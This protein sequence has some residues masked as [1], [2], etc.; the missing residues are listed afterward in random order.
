MNLFNN[1]VRSFLREIIFDQSPDLDLRERAL[2]LL[3]EDAR[4]TIRL[5]DNIVISQFDYDEIVQELK[6]N[7]KIQAIKKLREVTTLDLK[8]AK[9]I[10]ESLKIQPEQNI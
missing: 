10:V 7:R 9:E 5:A 6:N 3:L 4:E 2:D 1:E 8:T